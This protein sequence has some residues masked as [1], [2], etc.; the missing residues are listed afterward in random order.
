MWRC[1][2]QNE[3]KWELSEAIE[4]ALR[5]LVRQYVDEAAK[6]TDKKRKEMLDQ[7]AADAL[8]II[9]KYNSTQ[10]LAHL[11]PR[12]ESLATSRD[13]ESNFDRIPYLLGVKN[14]VIDLRTGELRERRRE[15]NI[16]RMCPVV[17]DPDAD[18]SFVDEMYLATM[19]DDA[20]MRD[21]L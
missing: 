21:Y 3:F 14:G 18:T 7:W 6:E 10:G 13:F 12:F 16:F 15:D 9:K 4:R 20:E 1:L 19:A 8:S 17:Y 2:T 11:Y 5:P